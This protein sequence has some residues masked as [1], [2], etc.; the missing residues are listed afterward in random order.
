MDFFHNLDSG[1]GDDPD[2]DGLN[3]LFE[4]TSGTSPL[5]AAS[6]LRLEPVPGEETGTFRINSVKPGVSYRLEFSP[7]LEE[8]SWTLL[9]ERTYQTTGP[10][11]I[12]GGIPALPSRLF[13]RV[14]VEPAP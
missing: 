6:A 1:P 7:D 2:G 12:S 5:D 8:S 13:Y 14:S 9:T 4:W 11:I 10:A 3:N